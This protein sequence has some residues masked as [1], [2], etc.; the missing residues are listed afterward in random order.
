MEQEI[1]MTEMEERLAHDDD[2]SYRDQLL[3]LISEEAASLK[4][5]LDAGLPPEEF[6][7][8]EKVHQ[9]LLAAEKVINLQWKTV[10]EP[11]AY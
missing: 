1:R 11:K 3:S 5:K 7:Q 2:G 8:A 9:A 4:A 6:E 10:R